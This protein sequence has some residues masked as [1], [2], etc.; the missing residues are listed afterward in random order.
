MT[1]N[2]SVPA[3][4]QEAFRTTIDNWDAMQRS[5]MDSADEDANRFERTFYEFIDELR[6]WMQTWSQKPKTVD[7]AMERP[8]ITP[9]FDDLPG[10]L[11]LNLETEMELIVEGI[12]RVEEEKYD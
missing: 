6:D 2:N 1:A 4:V 3:N 8:E 5:D 9:F 12:T 10:P 11:H 7:E